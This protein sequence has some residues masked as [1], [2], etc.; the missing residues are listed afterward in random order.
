MTV[1][2]LQP[3]ASPEEAKRRRDAVRRTVDDEGRRALVAATF[4]P[5]GLDDRWTGG[6]WIGGSSTS[7]GRLSA[8]VLGHGDAP[9]DMTATQIRVETRPI[10]D[11]TRQEALWDS[12]RS[13]VQHF[14]HET[15]VLP[16]DVRRAVFRTD[17]SDIDP[18]DPWESAALLV[19]GVLVEFR[20]LAHENYWVSQAPVDD[21]VVAIQAR[22]W[23]LADTG[24]VSIEDTSEYREGRGLI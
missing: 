15:G 16:D 14:W 6:R 10:D 9:R 24:L 1:A 7:N 22:G 19:D 5:F 3:P 21:A 4:T 12:A 18:T 2:R 17:G 23:S 20:V 11:R 8:L 13:Q